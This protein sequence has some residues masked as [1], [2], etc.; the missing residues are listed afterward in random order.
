MAEA[1]DT[2]DEVMENTISSHIND[3]LESTQKGKVGS[4]EDIAWVDSCLIKESDIS[5]DNWNS[6]KAALVEI[7]DSHPESLGSSSGISNE[8]HGETDIEI[9]PS[10]EETEPNRFSIR[11]EL[12]TLNDD[13][14]TNDNIAISKKA[15]DLQSFTFEGNPFLPG[16]KD[17]LGVTENLELGVNKDSWAPEIEPS[18]EDIFKVWNL[19]VPEEEDEL[20]KQLNNALEEVLPQSLP[21]SFADSDAHKNLEE[22]SVN[23][24]IAGIADLSLNQIFS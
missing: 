3:S 19:E 13:V 11:E 9:H 8:L 23:D 21:S 15:Y 17:E 4:P 14:Q 5:D 12:E 24:L 10:S 1:M 16:Y 2:G 7:L 22:T 6:L 20:V 18:T